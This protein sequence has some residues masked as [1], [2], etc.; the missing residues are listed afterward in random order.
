MNDTDKVLLFGAGIACVALLSSSLS[1]F[2]N[3][4]KIP[5]VELINPKS[6]S[7]IADQLPTNED[8][9]IMA[10]HQFVSDNVQYSGFDSFLKLTPY[11]IFCKDCYLPATVLNI[12]R[13]N[14]VGMSVLLESLLRNR[15][16]ANRTYLVIGQL[17]QGGVGGHAWVNVCRS[18]DHWYVLESTMP[19]MGWRRQS[20]LESVYEPEALVNDTGLYCIDEDICFDVKTARGCSCNMIY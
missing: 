6:V 8:D 10:A 19:P 17:H 7:H 20:E 18:D 9:F 12:G 1:P 16:P 5:L 2:S 14:C 11:Y 3:K 13:S 15:I 4:A